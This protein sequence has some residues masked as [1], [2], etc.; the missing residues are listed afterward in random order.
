M[1]PFMLLV[2]KQPDLGSMLVFVVITAGMLFVAGTNFKLFA[3]V[4][5][6][7]L[8]SMPL[9]YYVMEPHQRQRIDAFFKS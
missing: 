5:V 9:A 8:L 7:G 2:Y 4:T 6:A 1:L 3:G